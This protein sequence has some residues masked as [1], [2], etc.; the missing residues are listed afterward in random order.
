PEGYRFIG[1]VKK[2]ALESESCV[3]GGVECTRESFLR[4]GK[5]GA[6]T[7][8]GEDGV[9]KL[10]QCILGP[11]GV[12]RHALQRALPDSRLVGGVGHGIHALTNCRCEKFLAVRR[13][14]LTVDDS[15]KGVSILVGPLDEGPH[16]ILSEPELF[17]HLPGRLLGLTRVHRGK[18]VTNVLDS[19]PRPGGTGDKILDI[20]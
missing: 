20:G 1:R 10:I 2:T 15:R 19:I 3:P 5:V 18:S 7:R 17:D 14:T 16:P 6:L 11:R 4:L 13:T 9:S 12:L 8:N